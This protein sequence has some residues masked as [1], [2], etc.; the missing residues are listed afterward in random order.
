MTAV[1]VAG[2]DTVADQR[3]P[4]MPV[5][6]NLASSGLWHTYGVA[7]F[8]MCNYFVKQ[9]GSERLPHGFP[10]TDNSYTGFGGVLLVMGMNPYTLDTNVPLAYDLACPVERQPTIRVFVDPETFEAICPVCSSHYN[11]TT[12]AGA[13]TAGPALE[14]K[15]KYGLKR[16]GCH[17][18]NQQGYLITD[19]LD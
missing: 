13:P 2:C 17:A 4:A 19:R 10:Y 12:A 8:G 5:S 16:Y 3:I 11:V 18:T 15:T 9:E 6:I 1:L 7:G 14:G